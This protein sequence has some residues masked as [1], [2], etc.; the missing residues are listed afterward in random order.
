MERSH[1][2]RCPPEAAAMGRTET[3]ARREPAVQH[4][5]RDAVLPRRRLRAVLQTRI[6]PPL[7]GDPCQDARGATRLHHRAGRP[8]PL[9]LRWRH[10]LANRAL[11]VACA[12]LLRAGAARGRANADLLDGWH[13]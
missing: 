2:R 4:D 3:P 5:A 11:G 12:R 13:A 1:E 10:A 7:C 6:Y 8:E 9:E